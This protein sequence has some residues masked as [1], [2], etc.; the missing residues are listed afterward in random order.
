LYVHKQ[1]DIVSTTT[2]STGLFQVNLG[3]LVSTRDAPIRQ[4][5]DYRLDDN[6]RLTIGQLLINT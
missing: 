4:E 1:T 5:A 3:Q 2:V 6:R